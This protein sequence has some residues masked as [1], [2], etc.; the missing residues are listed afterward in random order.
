MGSLSIL[1][2]PQRIPDQMLFSSDVDLYLRNDPNRHLEIAE[3][4]EDSSFHLQY[5]Y[6]A[7]PI[8][9]NL[10]ALPSGWEERLIT[11][12]FDNG[13]TA[14]FLDPND[15]AISKYIR[16]QENDLRWI[17][18]GIKSKILNLSTIEQRIPSVYC[19]DGEIERAQ[20]LIH[21]DKQKYARSIS[22]GFERG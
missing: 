5:G 6:Y 1:G 22:K 12:H 3:V 10:V 20:E 13:I 2:S 19:L 9:P 11:K 14:L 21:A 7:D 8:T 17:G 16:G 15:C 18:E 4:G